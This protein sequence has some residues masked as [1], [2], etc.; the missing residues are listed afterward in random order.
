LILSTVSAGVFNPAITSTNFIL[1][2]GLKKCIPITALSNP[3]P[4]SVIESDEVFVAK[5][6]VAGTI[7]CNSLNVCCFT[8]ITSRA[9]STT[10]SASVQ[11]SFVPVVIFASNPSAYS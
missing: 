9:A 4:I 5:I 1:F 6:H 7:S 3:A 2:A 8:A 11:I 10:K